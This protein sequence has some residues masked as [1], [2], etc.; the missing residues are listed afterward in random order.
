MESNCYGKKMLPLPQPLPHHVNGPLLSCWGSITH[1]LPHEFSFEDVVGG[2]TE[3]LP[4]KFWVEDVVGGSTEATSRTAWCILYFNPFSW[5]HR[6]TGSHPT[7][8]LT[9]SNLTGGNL[10]GSSLTRSHILHLFFLFSSMNFF[11]ACYSFELSY[12]IIDTF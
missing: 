4:H 8:S 3:H 11:P 10:T 9:G 7:G 5:I 1:H 12:A 2:S 6:P